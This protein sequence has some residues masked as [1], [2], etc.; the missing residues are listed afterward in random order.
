MKKCFY[1][2]VGP[3]KKGAVCVVPLYPH[4]LMDLVNEDT[5]F[6]EKNV[7]KVGK[8][9]RW[10]DIIWFQYNNSNYCIS[11]NF[12]KLLEENKITGWTSFPIIL[13]NAPQQ[14]HLFVITG[15]AGDILNLEELN[16]GDAEFVEFD[17]NTWDGSDIFRLENTGY[18]ACTLQFKELFEKHNIT[19]FKFKIL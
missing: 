15:K 13:E 18:F 9:A 7:F 11:E 8:G 6:R 19:N 17:L 16:R 10:Y 12:K 1:Y 5:I 4:D 2:V 3:E 14:Y